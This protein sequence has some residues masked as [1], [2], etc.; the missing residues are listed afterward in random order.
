MVAVSADVSDQSIANGSLNE[1]VG[2]SDSGAPSNDYALRASDSGAGNFEGNANRGPAPVLQDPHSG[3]AS[4]QTMA[5]R[6]RTSNTGA[7][8]NTV[9]AATSKALKFPPKSGC[10]AIAVNKPCFLTHP[11]MGDEAVA[12]GRTGGSWRAKAQKFGKLCEQG[13]QMVQI[14]KVLLPKIRLLHVEDRHQFVY[15]ED[16]IVKSTGSNVFVKWDCKYLHKK[17]F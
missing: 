7:D 16:A 8:T 11:D 2:L 15:L 9:E 3:S 4:F 14:Y 6:G 17:S 12:E 10:E 1:S 5:T 13:E